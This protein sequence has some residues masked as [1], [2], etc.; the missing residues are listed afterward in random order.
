MN[1]EWDIGN[2]ARNL[3]E[4]SIKDR[5]VIDKKSILRIL[6]AFIIYFIIMTSFYY[7]L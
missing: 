6:V 3:D 2:E 7:F 1:Q 5:L 4:G